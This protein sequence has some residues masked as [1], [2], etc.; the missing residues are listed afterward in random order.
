MKYSE[1]LSLDQRAFIAGDEGICPECE[2][3]V[4]WAD[5]DKQWYLCNDC[6]HMLLHLSEGKIEHDHA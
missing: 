4:Q 5:I 1:H 3:T 6:V 2:R